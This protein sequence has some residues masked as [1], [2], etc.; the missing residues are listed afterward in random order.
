MT[1]LNRSTLANPKLA[2]AAAGRGARSDAEI[3]TMVMNTTFMA[4]H[5]QRSE[6]RN[7]KRGNVAFW[8]VMATLTLVM[9]TQFSSFA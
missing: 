2:D 4:R 3:A 9:A 5:A 6:E 7:I 8:V 1:T